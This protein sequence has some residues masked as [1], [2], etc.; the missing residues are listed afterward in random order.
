MARAVGVFRE[1]AVRVHEMS[2]EQERMKVEAEQK[3]AEL[4]C[5]M[6]NDFDNKMAA[7]LDR[8]R[9]PPNR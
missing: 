8:C 6:A 5:S 1:N 3:R 9:V 4:V 2:L 7:V